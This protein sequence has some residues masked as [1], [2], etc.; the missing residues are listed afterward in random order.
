MTYT[1]DECR[2]EFTSGQVDFMLFIASFFRSMQG[3]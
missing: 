1:G 2:S 3:L